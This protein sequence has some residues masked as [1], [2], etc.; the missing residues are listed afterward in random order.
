MK[1][2]IPQLKVEDIAVAIVPRDDPDDILWDTYLINLKEEAM[3][4][5]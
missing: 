4:K 3:A 1:K 5:K 2:D